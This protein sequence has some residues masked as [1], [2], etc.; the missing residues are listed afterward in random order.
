[1]KKAS[2]IFIVAGII[3]SGM[4]CVSSGKAIVG[5]RDPIALVS[6]VSNGDINWKGEGPTD[7][8]TTSLFAN[9]ALR[10]DPDMVVASSAD[11]LINTAEGLIRGA[12]DG[13]V[14]SLAE[15]E[16]V[17]QS[18]AYRNASLNNAQIRSKMVKPAD[19]LFVNY[20][21]KNF[22]VVLASETGIQRSMF[23]E[24]EFTKVMYSGFGK[25]GECRAVL[26][27]TIRILD[28]TGKTLYH[29]TFSTWSKS[30]LRASGGLYS[31]TGLMELFEAT[32][33]E[34]CQDFLDSL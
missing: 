12:F 7:P 5:Q 30:T 3:L 17:L 18:L 2:F 20:R 24:F 33:T 14:I 28:N 26:D 1:L 10:E 11:G 23:V 4:G 15:K 19:Y 25:N 16:T 8:N 9:R 6:V 13:S 22:P 21:D 34:M 31:Q 27:M 29:K 32:I